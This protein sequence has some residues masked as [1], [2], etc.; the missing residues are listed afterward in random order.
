MLLV[1]KL[2]A[3]SKD[4]KLY[5]NEADTKQ[6]LD[7]DRSGKTV[8]ETIEARQAAFKQAQ[9]TLQAQGVSIPPGFDA[10]LSEVVKNKD[11][12]FHFLPYDFTQSGFELKFLEQALTV[13][14]LR[15]RQLEL[16]YNGERNLTDFKIQCHAKVKGAWQRVGEYTPDFLLLE[17]QE[18]KIYRAMIIETKGS[19]FAEQ[20]G[21]QAR[22]HFVETEFI[23]MNNDKFGYRRFHYLY[24]TD[25]DDMAAN[26]ATLN[27][28]ILNF[29]SD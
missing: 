21:F 7:I 25:A 2:S 1:E 24:L 20:K 23:R 5:P 15:R 16:Y 3:V 10:N 4:R 18:G 6:I 17:R 26:L 13:E 12:T 28:E 27:A 8:E 11:R 22:K 14:A 19:G 9:E 29:F